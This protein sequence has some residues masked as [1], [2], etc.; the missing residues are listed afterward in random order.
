VVKVSN[1]AEDTTAFSERRVHNPI[2][3]VKKVTEQTWELQM[4]WAK[5]KKTTRVLLK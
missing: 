1:V 4:C 2:E 5:N 3:W